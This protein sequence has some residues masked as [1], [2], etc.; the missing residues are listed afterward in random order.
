MNIPVLNFIR[1]IL[2][3]IL[4]EIQYLRVIHL[5]FLLTSAIGNCQRRGLEKNQLLKGSS[6]FLHLS[7]A[8]PQAYQE[9][10]NKGIV[11][12]HDTVKHLLPGCQQNAE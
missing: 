11:G 5:V 10:R 6:L 1:M 3:F 4:K 8:N 12:L 2:T 7:S 9:T